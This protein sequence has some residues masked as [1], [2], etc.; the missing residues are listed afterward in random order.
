MTTAVE[1]LNKSRAS[2]VLT[3]FIILMFIYGI[4][5]IICDVSIWCCIPQKRDY[6]EEVAA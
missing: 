3:I 1:Q 2:V 5:S 6:Y 4:V